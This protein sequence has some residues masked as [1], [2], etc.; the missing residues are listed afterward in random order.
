MLLPPSPA[1][2]VN[3]RLPS[4][5]FGTGH[6]FNNYYKDVLGSA[7]NSRLGAQMLVENS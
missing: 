7:I 4:F 2:D 3:S 1:Q 6:I 5:R